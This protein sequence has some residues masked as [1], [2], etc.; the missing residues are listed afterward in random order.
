MKS[1][2]STNILNL[3]IVQIKE[4]ESELDEVRKAADKYEEDVSGSS[5]DRDVELMDSQVFEL[6]H[7]LVTS[8]L[9]FYTSLFYAFQTAA[10]F[11][12]VSTENKN[13]M[14]SCE[15]HL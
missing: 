8:A 6:L 10:L 12:K 2:L 14:V 13:I 11:F 5:Q 1:L 7:I 3:L 15:T 9:L 4:L